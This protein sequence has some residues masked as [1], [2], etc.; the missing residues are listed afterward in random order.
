MSV[1]VQVMTRKACHLC[2]DAE[3]FVQQL[4][5]EGLCNLMLTDVD[6]DLQLA[7]RYGADVPIIF[8]N[9]QE[10]MRHAVDVETL[11]HLVMLA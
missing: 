2:E 10:V 9:D 7:V 4:H 11:R 3:H 1:V 8:I 6:A 5:D